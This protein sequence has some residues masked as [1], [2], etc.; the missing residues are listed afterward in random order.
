MKQSQVTYGQLDRV[1]RALGFVCREVK[2]DPPALRY[3]HK[4]SGALVSLPPLPKT[5][6]VLV[7]HLIGTRTTLDLFG[8][9]EPTVFDAKL[10]KAG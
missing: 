4:E 2:G 1:L 3:E 7:H 8:I 5:D 9:A 6:F 10:Q